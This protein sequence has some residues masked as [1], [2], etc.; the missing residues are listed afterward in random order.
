MVLRL[1]D[2]DCLRPRAQMGASPSLN[3]SVAGRPV[4][5]VCSEG[6][7]SFDVSSTLP[8]AHSARLDTVRGR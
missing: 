5:P 7:L 6:N 1:L 4:L 8:G 3:D 2:M